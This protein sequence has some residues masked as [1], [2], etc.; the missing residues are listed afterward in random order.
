MLVSLPQTT[1]PSQCAGVSVPTLS[2]R[3][4]GSKMATSTRSSFLLRD[5]G[6]AS[7]RTPQGVN[8]HRAAHR[9]LWSPAR[10]EAWPCRRCR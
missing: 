10:L 6:G 3:R 2:G 4:A 1:E 8:G 5:A 9:L 7:D